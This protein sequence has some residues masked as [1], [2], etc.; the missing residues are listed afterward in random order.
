[1]LFSLYMLECLSVGLERLLLFSY[2]VCKGSPQVGGFERRGCFSFGFERIQ[3]LHT[4]EEKTRSP[5]SCVKRLFLR[6]V[7]VTPFGVWFLILGFVWKAICSESRS[8]FVFVFSS[9][10]VVDCVSLKFIVFVS[11]HR[12]GFSFRLFASSFCLCRQFASIANAVCICDKPL[13]LKRISFSIANLGNVFITSKHFSR[14][15]YVFNVIQHI[16]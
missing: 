11:L 5:C 2:S 4:S 10:C 16:S 1:M 9:V 14:K 3:F 6:R 7:P 12:L 13:L 15:L 8:G